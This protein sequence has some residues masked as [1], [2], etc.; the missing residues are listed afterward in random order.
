MTQPY[1]PRPDR[2]I[3]RGDDV[4]VP[5]KNPLAS[6]AVWGL[7]TAAIM[8]AVTF[9]VRSRKIPEALGQQVQDAALEIAG[10]VVALA[11][12]LYGRWKAR[13]PLGMSAGRKVVRIKCLLPLL[14]LLPA[15]GAATGG[16]VHNRPADVSP[17]AWR[18]IET[19]DTYSL[20]VSAVTAVRVSGHINDADA[21]KVEQARVAA[22]AALDFYRGN[23]SG[24]SDWRRQWANLLN[25][26]AQIGAKD[27]VDRAKVQAKKRATVYEGDA[28]ALAVSDSFRADAEAGW[29]ATLR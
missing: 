25:V 19:Q 8:Y 5:T 28:A 4:E 7:I 12:A 26:I 16:C 21:R 10:F 20:T 17:Q 13:Q 6:T 22:A 14:I 9:L 3:A 27:D 24:E 2:V 15:F 29:R 1:T 18:F 11:V 23:L